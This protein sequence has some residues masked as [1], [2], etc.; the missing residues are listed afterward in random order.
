MPPAKPRT[1]RASSRRY[2]S[3][4]LASIHELALDL[5]KAGLVDLRDMQ[6]FD[7]ICLVLDNAPESRQKRDG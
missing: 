3:A 1:T 6:R 4:P 5:Y 7:R 2:K